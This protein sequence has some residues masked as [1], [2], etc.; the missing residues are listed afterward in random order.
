MVSFGE[1]ADDG[2]ASAMKAR[3]YKDATDLVAYGPEDALAFDA[4]ASG[5]TGHA[6]GPVAGALHGGGKH[7]GRGAVVQPYTLA[8]RGRGD[9]RL[10]ESRQDGTANAIVSSDGGRDGMGVGAVAAPIA[11]S[12]KDA[13]ADTSENVSPTLRASSHK[14]GRANAGA[15]PAIAFAQNQRGEIRTSDA[16]FSLSGQGGKPGQGYPA[17]AHPEAISFQ[18]RGRPDGRTI[19]H[20]DEVAYALTAPD[21]GGRAQERN[22]ATKW[23]VRRLTPRECERLQGFPDDFTMIPW[24]GKDAEDCPAGVRYRALGNSMAVNVMAFIGERIAQVELIARD[25]K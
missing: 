3:D 23:A 6:V 13:A 22:I 4:Q 24:K 15:P 10:L 21:G 1:Y 25:Q 18:E 16:A 8:V 9:K 17:V 14:H 11:F 5:K 7:G 19:E 20:L 2:T 12:S